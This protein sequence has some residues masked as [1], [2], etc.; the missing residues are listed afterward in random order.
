MAAI[1]V[2]EIIVLCV[3][4]YNPY[5]ITSLFYSSFRNDFIDIK[6]YKLSFNSFRYFFILFN[7]PKK[8]G[9]LEIKDAKDRENLYWF[10]KTVAKS[11]LHLGNGN[12]AIA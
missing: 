7:Y 4:F 3:S 1:H 10:E 12:S 6:S 9:I 2:V 5:H 11:V 8:F